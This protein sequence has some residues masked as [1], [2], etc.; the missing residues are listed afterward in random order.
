MPQLVRSLIKRP[1]AGSIC[2]SIKGTEL[3]TG[4]ARPKYGVFVHYLALTFSTLLSSQVSVAH[5]AGVFC[6]GLGQLD[7]RYEVQQVQVKPELALFHPAA[8]QASRSM[9]ALQAHTYLD[10]LSAS[11]F[12]RVGRYGSEDPERPAPR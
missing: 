7:Q 6:S 4:I 9:S 10:I 8:S 11:G 12:L 2:Q 3:G 1:N 5:L